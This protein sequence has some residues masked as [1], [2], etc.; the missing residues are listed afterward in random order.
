M[1]VLGATETVFGVGKMDFVIRT[2]GL[3]MYNGMANSID[4]ARWKGG[5]IR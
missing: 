2:D 5:E 3:S 1:E 4:R